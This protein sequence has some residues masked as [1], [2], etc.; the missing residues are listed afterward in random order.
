M[1]IFTIFSCLRPAEGQE[2]HFRLVLT[3]SSHLPVRVR[4]H[5]VLPIK[6]LEGHEL[7]GQFLAG[8]QIQ[9]Q[10]NSTTS[11]WVD[12]EELVKAQDVDAFDADGNPAHEALVDILQEA[13]MLQS[14]IG[15]SFI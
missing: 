14:F 11:P 6:E 3:G 12:V 9:L 10:K 8:H 7:H 2:G 13:R 1:L 4:V 15:K 5:D